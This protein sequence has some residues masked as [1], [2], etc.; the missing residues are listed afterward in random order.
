IPREIRDHWMKQAIETLASPC[1]FATF[2]SVIVNHTRDDD[3][4][5]LICTGANDIATGNPT[6]HGEIAAI[7]NCSAVLTEPSGR[8]GLTGAEV[9]NA[10]SKL[11]LYTTAEPCPMCAAA[12]RWAGFRECVFGTSIPTLIEQ[13]WSQI[14]LRACE[15]F[16]RSQG[17]GGSTTLF[18][19]DLDEETD[20]LFAWQ[21]N[22]DHASP[23]GCERPHNS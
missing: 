21:F 8:W 3:L 20:A 10:F 12:I 14:Q 19:S 5:D 15:V 16:E 11:T 6:L 1:A 18:E 17:I 13:G 7:N 22:P 9:S 2:G 23:D 4:G